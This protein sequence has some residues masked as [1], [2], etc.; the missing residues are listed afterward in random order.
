MKKQNLTQADLERGFK[1]VL[2]DR[3]NDPRNLFI[4][5][6]SPNS[7][8]GALMKWNRDA[9]RDHWKGVRTLTTT[10]VVTQQKLFKINSLDFPT[11]IASQQQQN[12]VA[13]WQTAWSLNP[14][15][16]I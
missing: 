2:L 12:A 13:R 4:G 14:T 16:Y 5:R 15:K 11:T 7:S 8:G 10:A 1:L 3:Y 9:L 6:S